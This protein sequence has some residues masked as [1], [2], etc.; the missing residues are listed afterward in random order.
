VGSACATWIYCLRNASTDIGVKINLTDKVG[1][2]LPVQSRGN[3]VVYVT[4]GGLD[5]RPHLRNILSEHT[6]CS[7]SVCW[8]HSEQDW[9]LNDRKKHDCLTAT[10]QQWILF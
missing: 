6:H 3:G 10:K 9:K 2:S 5:E 4:S 8:H 1:S 7:T